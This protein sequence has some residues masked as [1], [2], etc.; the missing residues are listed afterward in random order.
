M[1]SF[2]GI[3]AVEYIN[4]AIDEGNPLKTVDGLMLPTAKIR[5]VDPEHAQHYQDVLY[6]A[7]SQKLM[8]PASASNIL[9]LDEIQHAVYEANMHHDKAKQYVLLN[10]G[11]ICEGHLVLISLAWKNMCISPT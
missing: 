11:S 9:W 10:F 4:E 6:H 1:D 8:D 5:D 3:V 7:K 2:S